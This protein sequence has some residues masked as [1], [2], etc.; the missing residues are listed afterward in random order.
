MTSLLRGTARLCTLWLGTWALLL[1]P[2]VLLY[3]EGY[4]V[5]AAVSL[6]AI[7]FAAVIALLISTARSRRFRLV[8]ITFLAVNQLIWT[9]YVVY[10]GQALSPEHL[11][12]FQHEA[13][14]TF[15][16][17]LADWRSLLPWLLTLMAG[18]AALV[19]L[20]WR[21][22]ANARWRSR[23]SGV[24]FVTIAV[25]ATTSWMLH[26]RI[27]AAFPGKHTASMYGPFQA[28]VG[29]VRMGLTHV[30]ADSLNV[31]GQTQSQT[32]FDSEAVTVVVIMGESINP[33]RLSLYGF[34][35][36]TTPQLARWRSSP[37]A[38]FT[39]IPQIG[40]SGGL[41]TYAS[42]PG[43]LRPAYWPVQAQEFGVNLFE[44]AHRQGF[45]SWYFS[46]QTLNFLEAAGG[47]PNAERVETVEDDDRL[48]GLAHEIPEGST[49]SFV[50]LHERVNHTPYTSNCSPAPEGLYI[51]DPETGS[52][53]ERRR[54]A[55]DN[56]L[57]CWDRD[58]SAMV[59]PF[60]KRAGAVHIFIT[61]DHS[62]LMAETGSWGHGFADLRV[63]MVPM[64]LLTNR[65]HSDVATLFKSWSPPTTYHLAQTVA[66]ALGVRLET[67]GIAA[68]LFFLNNTMPFALAGFMEVE[69]LKPGVYRVKHFARNG[70]LLSE[71]VTNLPEVGAANADY[72]PPEVLSI[73]LKGKTGTAGKAG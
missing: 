20:Q 13:A 24:T 1:L 16:G 66:R 51:F 22:G 17:V 11:I 12:L 38:G 62:E 52:T 29:A 44:L 19:A 61:A 25:A 30:A 60:L 73:P 48:T 23:V 56:G 4:S 35:A 32:P 72:G 69:Q 57:R 26:P 59:E 49:K 33:S 3:W 15:I 40:F 6:K 71:E 27:D 14:D 47:A 28:A 41:D 43:F 54:A 67:P 8:A 70:Q 9:G 64:M 31:I 37:P 65:P 46:A 34:K 36:D 58:V 42:V 2:D 53:E 45:K 63:A 10:F 5:K 21:E 18:S 39:L 68:N 50:F 7:L 55:Y